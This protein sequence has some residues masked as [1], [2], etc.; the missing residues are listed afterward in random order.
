[1]ELDNLVL[2]RNTQARE[3]FE[4]PS[5]WV[6]TTI[7]FRGK[8]DQTKWCT[9]PIEWSR[10]QVCNIDWL[11]DWFSSILFCFFNPT[12][13]LRR[14]DIT[15][16]CMLLQN[17]LVRYMSVLL[18][19]HLKNY[20][21]FIS[22]PF[23]LNQGNTLTLPNGVTSLVNEK[24]LRRPKEDINQF[25]HLDF[26]VKNLYPKGPSFNKSYEKTLL[27]SLCF[28]LLWK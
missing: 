17:R 6:G 2:E 4:P 25:Q 19:V 9:M 8:I 10:N 24:A 5:K 18:Y 22:L 16:F 1:M 14:T 23:P 3:G 20:V 11:I 28:N 27:P 7:N 26:D 12:S 15:T 21:F 13:Q